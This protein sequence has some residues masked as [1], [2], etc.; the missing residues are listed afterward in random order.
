MMKQ[1]SLQRSAEPF[2]GEI[3]EQTGFASSSYLA[4]CFRTRYQ[5]SPHAWRKK[6]RTQEV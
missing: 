1:T 5:L 4:R 2:V 6:Y 3:A